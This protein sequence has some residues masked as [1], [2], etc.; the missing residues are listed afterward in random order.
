L[1]SVFAG[2]AKPDA[3][4]IVRSYAHFERA[5]QEFLAHEAANVKHLRPFAEEISQLEI[6]DVSLPR[7][8]TPT[9]GMIYFK[10]PDQYRLWR[11]DY[12]DCRPKF[13]GFD[14]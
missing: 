12:V 6:E 1:A 11:C 4:L 5:V 10:G 3:T 8:A 13:L 7:P 14:D 2:D 9:S